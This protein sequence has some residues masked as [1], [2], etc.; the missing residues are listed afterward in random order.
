MLSFVDKERDDLAS[1]L[2]KAAELLSPT[3]NVTPDVPPLPQ[4]AARDNVRSEMARIFAPYPLQGRG[5]KHSKRQQQQYPES[6]NPP[7]L[8]QW[9][10]RFFCLALKDQVKLLHHAC[11]VYELMRG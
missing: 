4:T 6:R 5:R 1:S 11:I 8:L 10:H 2:R 3:P 9:S 7:Q